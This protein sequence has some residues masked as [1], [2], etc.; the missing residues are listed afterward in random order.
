[1]SFESSGLPEAVRVPVTAQLL[2]PAVQP[3]QRE[4]ERVFWRARRSW[5]EVELNSG[6]PALRDEAAKDGAPGVFACGLLPGE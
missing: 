3:S 5:I 4:M 1:M 2:E 6:D